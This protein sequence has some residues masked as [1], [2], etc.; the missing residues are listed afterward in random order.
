VIITFVVSFNHSC[1]CNVG[2]I[3][4]I[5]ALQVGVIM[6]FYFACTK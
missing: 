1:S 2:A 6:G 5:T 3:L 4:D